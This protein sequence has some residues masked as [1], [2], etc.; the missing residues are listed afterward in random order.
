MSRT[1][2]VVQRGSRPNRVVERYI[3][4]LPRAVSL[5]N[6]PVLMT[7]AEAGKYMHIAPSTLTKWRCTKQ[8]NLKYIK[9]G[10]R[11]MYSLDDIKEFLRSRTRGG[12]A[13]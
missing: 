1:R 6:N 4:D 11:I 3:D 9:I 7:E 5:I 10:N 12:E 2:K 8:Y 13:A